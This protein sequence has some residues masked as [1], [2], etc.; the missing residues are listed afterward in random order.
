MR[1][2]QLGV[3]LD[4]Q[5]NYTVYHFATYLVKCW[6]RTNLPNITVEAGST[7]QAGVGQVTDFVQNSNGRVDSVP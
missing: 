6:L 2:M 4:A 3:G 5:N 7:Y 1:G